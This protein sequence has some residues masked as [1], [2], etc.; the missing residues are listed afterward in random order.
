MGP[1]VTCGGDR[2]YEARLM[3]LLFAYKVTAN[4]SQLGFYM[5]VYIY[6]HTHTH[7]HTL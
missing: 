5:R 7:T 2:L 1:T 4:K 3:R 6:I